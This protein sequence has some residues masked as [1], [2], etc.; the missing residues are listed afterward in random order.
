MS[1]GLLALVL[2]L[3]LG[4]PAEAPA[5]VR[6]RDPSSGQCLQ[7][8]TRVIPWA[9]NERGHPTLGYERAHQAFL[10]SFSTWEEVSCSD[11]VFRDEGPTSETRVGHREGETPDNLIIFREQD[12]REVVA[13][14]AP[15]HKAGTCAND[16]DCWDHGST[17]IAVTT[18]TFYRRTGEIVDA[19][20]EMN[21][22]WFDFTD[23]DGPP[24][25]QGQTVGC[26]ATDIQNT[27]THEIGH[28]IG[29]NHTPVREATMFASSSRGEV[30]KR[31]LSEDDIA[32]ICAIYPA[33]RATPYCADFA[34]EEA[35]GGCGCG[36]GGDGVGAL[37]LFLAGMAVL[38]RSR[39]TSE[40]PRG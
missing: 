29:L 25:A 32:G 37:G 11:L 16:F 7:W 38:R 2:L 9:M 5:F 1:R 3:G 26:V 39:R 14:N 18:T 30:H 22:A 24:C 21:A 10:R 19:D 12:C 34:L 33:G 6:S 28:M 13:S 4:L 17:T 20:I 8:E 27:A 23:V 31:W 35:P 40:P 15:C 36:S